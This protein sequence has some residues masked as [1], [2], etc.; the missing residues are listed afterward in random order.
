MNLSCPLCL[1]KTTKELCQTLHR[2]DEC[3][4]VFKASEQHLE[5]SEEKARYETHQNKED[6]GYIGF[7]NRLRVPLLEHIRGFK[8]GLDYGCGPGPVLKRLLERDGFF[9][10]AYD[11]FFAP[12]L[13]QD[14]YDFITCTEAIEHF[15][16]PQKEIEQMLSLLK[17]GGVLALMTQTYKENDDLS[18]WWYARDPTHVCFYHQETFEW[19]AQ[20]YELDLLLN[21]QNLCFLKKGAKTLK[22]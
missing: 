19:L 3:K 7:L 20:K 11:P 1:K 21:K 6:D 22:I 17:Q 15:F 8:K 14:S 9:M 4:L 5:S 12:E 13:I 18:D 10:R 2:C 16:N